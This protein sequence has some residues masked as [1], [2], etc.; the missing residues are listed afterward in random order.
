MLQLSK[1]HSKEDMLKQKIKTMKHD[2]DILKEKASKSQNENLTDSDMEKLKMDCEPTPCIF[3]SN[4]DTH[5]NYTICFIILAQTLIS[6]T[7]PS[8]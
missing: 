6:Y 1:S 4:H 2:M 8:Y 7:K 5:I 3:C